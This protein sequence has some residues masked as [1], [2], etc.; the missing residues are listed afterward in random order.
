MKKTKG[1]LFLS[2]AVGINIFT[3]SFL[4]FNKSANSNMQNFFVEKVS[5][6]AVA[7]QGTTYEGVSQG[8][9]QGSDGACCGWG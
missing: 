7:P 4:N 3:L 6:D 8:G 5:A 1:I 2:L 9:C